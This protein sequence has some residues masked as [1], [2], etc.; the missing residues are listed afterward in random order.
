MFRHLSVESRVFSVYR[1]FAWIVATKRTPFSDYTAEVDGGG[2]E[3]RPRGCEC[4]GALGRTHH[5]R[6]YLD[7]KSLGSLETNVSGLAASGC[8]VASSQKVEAEPAFRVA[9]DDPEKNDQPSKSLE[10]LDCI[11]EG[12]LEVSADHIEFCVTLA[13]YSSVYL[14]S[15][16]HV[17]YVIHVKVRY[18]VSLA[19]MRVVS[20]YLISI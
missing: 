19:K 6:I 2:I 20:I 9:H 13:T 11:F 14:S 18:T 12:S 3:R 5:R 16:I 17:C 1:N 15:R 7:G 10:R 4:E 8:H